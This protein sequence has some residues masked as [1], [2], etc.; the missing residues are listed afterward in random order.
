MVDPGHRHGLAENMGK[1]LTPYCETDY[2]LNEE[3]KS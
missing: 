1:P 2:D 3:E